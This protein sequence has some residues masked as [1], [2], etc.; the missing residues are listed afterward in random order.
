MGSAPPRE[1]GNPNDCPAVATY[2]SF[3]P[4]VR[5]NNYQKDLIRHR[6]TDQ[7]TWRKALMYWKGNDYIGKNVQNILE[8]YDELEEEEQPTTNFRF[9]RMRDFTEDLGYD[10]LERYRTGT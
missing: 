8:K 4:R 9:D 6:A 10:P 7:G 5:L 1:E 3:Y 2:E